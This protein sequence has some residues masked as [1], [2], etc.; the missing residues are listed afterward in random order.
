MV[1]EYEQLLRLLFTAYIT[2]RVHIHTFIIVKSHGVMMLRQLIA[3]TDATSRKPSCF[4]G[5]RWEA[6]QARVPL[7]Q[8]QIP[9]NL[10]HVCLYTLTSR[11]FITRQQTDV[12]NRDRQT[13]RTHG[14]LSDSHGHGDSVT[15]FLQLASHNASVAATAPYLAVRPALSMGHHFPLS[16]YRPHTRCTNSR[17]VATH[18]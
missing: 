5:K 9:E 15:R 18:K 17:H 3:Y 16:A 1:D 4:C 10:V 13:E 14:R 6:A 12:D 11:M 7:Q 8:A 2:H